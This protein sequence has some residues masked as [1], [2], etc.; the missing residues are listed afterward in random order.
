MAAHSQT[1]QGIGKPGSDAADPAEDHVG[2]LGNLKHA[3]TET[4]P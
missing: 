3:S 1:L 4:Q 2:D